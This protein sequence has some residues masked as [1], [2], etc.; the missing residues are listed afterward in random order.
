MWGDVRQT[1]SRSQ[2]FDARRLAIARAARDMHAGNGVSFEKYL[3]THR[4]MTLETVHSRGRAHKVS[5]LSPGRVTADIA[6]F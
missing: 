1:M 2:S 6:A 3:V 5:A 4:V